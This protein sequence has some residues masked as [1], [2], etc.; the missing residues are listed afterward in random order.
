[1][2]EIYLS[3]EAIEH[4]KNLQEDNN[5]C[6]MADILDLTDLLNVLHFRKDEL[7]RDYTGFIISL[8]KLYKSL[9]K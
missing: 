1:M 9:K 4:I 5:E 6:L 3:P 2:E 7:K 8:M